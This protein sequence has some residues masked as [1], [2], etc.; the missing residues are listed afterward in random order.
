VGVLG[1]WGCDPLLARALPEVAS[2]LAVA[3][4]NR[5]P[6]LTTGYWW[7]A[8]VLPEPCVTPQAVAGLVNA[9]RYASAIVGPLNA[10]ACGAAG[11][12]A[13]A[14]NKPLV[15]WACEGAGA[16]TLVN[17]LPSPASVL[18]TM[19]QYFHWAHVAVVAAPQDLWVE[20]GAELAQELR[21][22][23][24]PVTVV[25]VAGEHE[26][27][28]ERALRR[29]QMADGVRVVVMCMHSV[30]LGGQEQKVL[31]EKAEDLGMTDGTF[32][33]IPY[34]AL[35]FPLP[36]R[37]V[38]YPVLANNTKLRLAYD[39]VLTITIDSPNTS[40]HEALEDARRAYE[41]P[42]HVNP[43]EV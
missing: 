42:K 17:P 6:G 18:H 14:W 20:A 8:V 32:V 35:T 24:L 34:D 2:S 40:F 28:A 39:A 10:A 23:G 43:T 1:P 3:R 33:F 21:A 9:D 25:T 30:L 36:Y 29:V 5:D 13:A 41:V 19:L 22:R 11:L 4:L 38:P 7:D 31:L 26:D 12:L 27:E 15:S 37:H 16:V